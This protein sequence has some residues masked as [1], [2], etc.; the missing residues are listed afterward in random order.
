M[1]HSPGGRLARMT[2]TA[3]VRAAAF[4]GWVGPDELADD[5]LPVRWHCGRTRA[6]TRAGRATS[7]TAPSGRRP[8]SRRYDALPHGALERVDRARRRHVDAGAQ[9][10]REP[11][12]VLPARRAAGR[13]R[14]RGRARRA[15]VEGRR[16]RAGLHRA[17]KVVLYLPS[18]PR[19]DTVAVALA[20][21]ARRPRPRRASR[22]PARSARPASCPAGRDQGRQSW[23]AVLCRS[24]GRQRSH[25]QRARPR[26]RRP[27]RAR[28][29]RRAGRARSRVRRRTP[30]TPRRGSP[31]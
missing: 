27:G 10:L 12:A 15:V 19:A 4:A 5:P 7:S 11:D 26:R 28:R 1:S 17:D 25:E 16:R 9:G 20:G 21:G 18:A 13:L 22:S 2:R 14:H 30:G 29:R 31:A 24:R 6:T 3:V 8:A 23:R